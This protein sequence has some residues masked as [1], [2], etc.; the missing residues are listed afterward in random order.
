MKRILLI[1]VAL[2]ALT[3]V[4][5]QTRMIS[6]SVKA[7]SSEPLVGVAVTIKGSTAG[8]VSDIDGCWSIRATRG[9]VLCFSCLGMVDKTVVVKSDHIDVVMIQDTYFVDDVV[10]IGYGTSKKSDLTGSVAS[11]KTSELKN[12]K[13]GMASNAL[14]GL[15]A[16]VQVTAGNL[17]PGADAGIVIRGAGSVNAGTSPL[18][19]VDGVPVSGL[20]DISTSDIQS[21]EVLKDASSAA[22]Y[23][24]RGS[25]GVVLITTRRGDKDQGRITFNVVAGAQKMLNKQDMMNAQQYYDLVSKSGQSYTWTTEELLLLSRGES[26]DWQDAV[27]Q[28]GSFQNYNLS[29]SGGSDK[30]THFLGVDW[31]DQRGIIK[32]SSFDKITV[33]YNADAVLKPWLRSGVRFNIVYSKLRNINEEADSGYGT[34]FSAISSQPTAPI[35]ASD[36]EYFDGFLNTKANPAAIVN[37]LDKS[38]KKLMAIGS[39]YIEAEP[40]KNLFIKTDNAVNYTTFRVNEYEDGRMGQHYPEDGAA[41]VTGNLSTYMQTENTVTYRLEVPRH[42]FSVIGGFSASRNTYETATA[43]SK[44]LNAITKYNNLGGAKDHGPNSSYASA[45]TLVSFYGRLTYNFDERYLFTATARGD[46]S[47]R[48]AEGHR[49]G[50]FPSA[51][52]AWRI[53]EESFL[54]NVRNVNNLKLRLSVGRLGNQNIG[55]YQ[56]AA[57]VG[58]GGYFVDYVFG[59]EKATGAVYE[60][61]SNPNLT[62]EK[63]NSFDAGLDFGFF[64][65]RLSGTVEAYYKRTSDLLWTVPLPYES[66]YISSLTNV[67]RLDNKGLEFTLNTVNINAESFQ[68]TSSFNFTLNRNNVVELYDGK[69][70]V[71][72]YIFVNH[73]LNEYYLLKSQGIWQMDEADKAAQYGCQPGDRK[74]YDKD[75][76]G[77]INGEDRVFCGQSTPTWYG[78]FSNT[79]S[80]FGIDLTVFMNFAGGHKINNSLLRYQNSYNIWGNMSQDYYNNYWTVDRP[81]NKY[82]APRIGSPYSNG[83][84]TDANLQKGNY[85]RIKNLELGYTFPS[86]LTRKFGSNSLRIYAS[87]QNLCTFTAFSGY[88]VEAWDTTNTYPGARAFIGGL[89]LSF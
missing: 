78:G 29:V 55:D 48:F 1:L 36:G 40:V 87:V 38:T 50:F 57:L 70:D 53:S 32:N 69:Q 51:A 77:V 68:W 42:K 16:G 54:K 21:I 37:L 86:R 82:P 64:N 61:I 79:F 88:D 83:D 41:S 66:G 72:K 19:V 28:V 81:S 44:S 3:D 8:T 65:G 46:G 49:W 80:F 89:T 76:N 34:M 25:N 43:T 75:N 47:S 58:Q 6:G 39:A 7:E 52:F 12:T 18:Y 30:L 5:G 63:A 14:Q 84:G 17:K 33:R 10:V 45:S 85:L 24:S 22:I 15:A 73:S 26:T 4:F 60:T 13:V 23:G 20:Q 59:G 71:G 67:G 11:I 31:Y 9:D 2:V 35:Y 27:T 74:I 62:W 56:Y